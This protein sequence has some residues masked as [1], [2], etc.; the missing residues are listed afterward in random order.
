MKTRFAF[1]FGGFGNGAIVLHLGVAKRFRKRGGFIH[2]RYNE[3]RRGI[4]KSIMLRRAEESKTKVEFGIR[5]K[6]SPMNWYVLNSDG[7][8]KGAPAGGGAIL[9]DHCGGFI[10]PLSLNF[11]Y[12]NTFKVEVM[13]LARGLELARELQISQLIMQ[14]DNL[15]CVQMIQHKEAGRNE[16]T[17]LINRCIHLIQQEDR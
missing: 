2:V 17:H 1:L 6:H 8:A 5:W 13:A 11:G 3:S 15:A 7:A 10:S 14:L 4:E 9:R 16:C 12:Y